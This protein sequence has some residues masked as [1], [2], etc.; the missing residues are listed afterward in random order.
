MFKHIQL[1]TRLGGLCLTHQ[2]VTKEC[3]GQAY[4]EISSTYE[5]YFLKT[6]HAYNDLVLK[7]LLEEEP[8]LGLR[9]LDLACGTGYNSVYL[10]KYYEKAHFDLVDISE[11]MLE[12][13][14]EKGLK[15]A[16]YTQQDMLSFLATQKDASFDR[17][18][19][20]WAI[21]YQPPQKIIK[22]VYR[23]LKPGGLFGVI[24]NTKG[25]LPE[26]RSIYPKLL[27]KE[28]KTIQKVMLELPNPVNKRTF[29]SW[30]EK[31]G[32]NVLEG[33]EGKHVFAFE[34][35]SALIDWV[36]HT[37]ALAGFDTMIDLKDES[38]QREMCKLLA[39]KGIKQVTHT[40][41]WGIF[42]KEE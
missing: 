29:D 14:K 37:G 39:E 25:T 26:I 23:V 15:N 18:I 34:E 35:E 9:V 12:Q 30:F 4:S 7:G 22:E 13:A 11:G 36:T 32:F 2:T 19:C 33:E 17:V 24:V 28:H 31:V 41:V 38:V 40:F 27:L 10:Q 21:K 8:P 5:D 20:C 16:T 6:M 3:I 42:K 1:L